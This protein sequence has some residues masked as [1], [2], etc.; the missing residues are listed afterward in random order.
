M[1]DYK[2]YDSLPF[3]LWYQFGDLVTSWLDLLGQKQNSGLSVSIQLSKQSRLHVCWRMP[4]LFAGLQPVESGASYHY[5]GIENNRGNPSIRFRNQTQ[6]SSAVGSCSTLGL[7]L[8]CGRSWRHVQAS[9][10]KWLWLNVPSSSWEVCFFL[11]V[12]PSNC[13]ALLLLSYLLLIWNEFPQ[14]I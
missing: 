2:S 12:E 9:L 11:G 13:L 7:L 3:F 4:S 6:P 1:R 5:R 14:S 8:R 10:Y